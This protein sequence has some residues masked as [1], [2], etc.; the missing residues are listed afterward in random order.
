MTAR[1]VCLKFSVEWKSGTKIEAALDADLDTQPVLVLFGASG[2]GKTT[3]L[4]AIAG[5]VRPSS[6]RIEFGS[7][8]WF[9]YEARI[10]VPVQHREIG[11]VAQDPALFPHM[12]VLQN[13][14]YGAARTESG[15]ELVAHAMHLVGV[16]HLSASR[17]SELSGGQRQRVALARAIA[18]Q[19]KLLLLDEPLSALDQKA[20]VALRHELRSVLLGSGIPT[21]LVTHDRN[22]ALCLGDGMA[23]MTEGRISQHGPI[24]EV[25]RKPASPAVADAIG[26]ETVVEGVVVE[27]RDALSRVRVGSTEVVAI[28]E[29][30]IE[31]RVLVC[32]RAMDVVLLRGEGPQA[33]ARTRLNGRVLQVR[34]GLPMNQV[35]ID[36]GFHLEALVTAEACEELALAEGTAVI[37]SVKAPHVHLLP[38]RQ[39]APQSS[40]SEA[41]RLAKDTAG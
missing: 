32:I 18:R 5:L 9:D 10:D 1:R 40:L 33:S 2:V 14:R 27:T 11:Y 36:C 17:P 35:S 22:E 3:V 6:G 30:L 25:L 31:G 24:R 16:T 34:A 20:R 23:V 39:D 28:N 41:T 21:I 15:R 29:G 12:N 4:R 38:L 7:T 8:P 13:V 19:P 26:I 37:A